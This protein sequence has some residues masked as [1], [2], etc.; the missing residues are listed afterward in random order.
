MKEKSYR[1]RR[2][3]IMCRILVAKT[4]KQKQSGAPYR[5]ER[6]LSPGDLCVYPRKCKKRQLQYNISQ[7]EHCRR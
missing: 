6:G 4:L 2:T 1:V 3:L 7:D 5:A